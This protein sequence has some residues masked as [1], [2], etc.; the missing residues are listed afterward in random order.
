MMSLRGERSDRTEKTAQD[1]SREGLKMDVV[2]FLHDGDA[3]EPQPLGKHLLI[4]TYG[5]DCPPDQVLAKW[6]S[7]HSRVFLRCSIPGSRF[8]FEIAS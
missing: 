7:S 2:A 5:V 6:I 4:W 3:R 1:A 8:Y